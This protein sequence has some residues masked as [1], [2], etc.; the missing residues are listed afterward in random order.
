MVNAVPATPC[1]EHGGVLQTHHHSRGSLTLVAGN[2]VFITTSPE[3]ANVL[4]TDVA[5]P[6][7]HRHQ[8][9]RAQ[10]KK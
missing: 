1:Q 9:I 4:Q 3:K 8:A 6:D 7:M 10:E 5:S 2:P